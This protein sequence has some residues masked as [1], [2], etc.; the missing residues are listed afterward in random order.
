MIT[1]G[2][3]GLLTG[4]SDMGVPPFWASPGDAH[5]TRVLGFNPTLTLTQI[6]KVI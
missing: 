1:G 2:W 4:E 6:A 5:I 3:D